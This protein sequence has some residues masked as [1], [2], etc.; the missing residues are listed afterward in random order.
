M[1]CARLRVRGGR[2]P[3]GGLLLG[4]LR[5]TICRRGARITECIQTGVTLTRDPV[6]DKEEPGIRFLAADPGS[7]LCVHDGSFRAALTGLHVDFGS[8]CGDE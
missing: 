5:W 1:T 6:R 4:G 2:E 3:A 7:L 8:I